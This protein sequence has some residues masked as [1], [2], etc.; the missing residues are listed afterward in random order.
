LGLLPGLG[1]FL[2]YFA[3]ILVADAIARKFGQS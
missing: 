3:D 1:L 2:A